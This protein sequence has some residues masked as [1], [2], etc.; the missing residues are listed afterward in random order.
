MKF[1][2]LFYFAFIAKF[3]SAWCCCGK[4]KTKDDD[5]GPYGGSTENLRNTHK[6]SGQSVASPQVKRGVEQS[7]N[8]ASPEVTQDATTRRSTP[9]SEESRV[10]QLTGQPTTTTPITLDLANPNKADINVNIKEENGVSF[11]GYSPKRAFHISSVIDGGSSV[12]KAEEGERCKFVESH[13]KGDSSLISIGIS[14]GS[15]SEAKFFE[16]VGTVWKSLTRDD[17]LNKLNEMRKSGSSPNPS[18][19]HPSTP[20]QSSQ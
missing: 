15:D 2:A 16:K 3:C 19:S 6:P 9:T 11:K 13:A 1:L 14:K 4:S 5:N 8:E 12:W 7:T 10:P 17:F 18:S 20:S